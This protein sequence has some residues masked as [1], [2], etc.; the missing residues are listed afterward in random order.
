MKECKHTDH[1]TCRDNRCRYFRYSAW[2]C[3][4]KYHGIYQA[5]GPRAYKQIVGLD[6]ERPLWDTNEL[7]VENGNCP[8]DTYQ[9]CG[10]CAIHQD[11]R[12]GHLKT[13][14]ETYISP[15]TG[16]VK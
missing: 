11:L 13:G 9:N 2:P 8:R 10:E 16:E 1:D 7:S 15:F 12:L 6:Y 3:L 14:P 4:E 5:L